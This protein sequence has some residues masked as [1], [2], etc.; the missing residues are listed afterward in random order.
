MFLYKFLFRDLLAENN[1]KRSGNKRIFSILF[2]MKNNT[3]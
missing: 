1:K 3:V 2:F